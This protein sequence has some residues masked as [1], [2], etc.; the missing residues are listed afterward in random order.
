[1][2]SVC[3]SVMMIVYNP[4]LL[5]LGTFYIYPVLVGFSNNFSTYCISFI[6]QV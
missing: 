5:K 2:S 4:S 6:R 1:M 3:G